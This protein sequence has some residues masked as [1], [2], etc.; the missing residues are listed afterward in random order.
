[1]VSTDNLKHDLLLII[2]TVLFVR[3]SIGLGAEE[4]GPS[5]IVIP[6]V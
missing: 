2:V 1:M 4:H 3:F 6:P 5:A